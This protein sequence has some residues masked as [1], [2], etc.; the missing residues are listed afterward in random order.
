MGLHRL[1]K[2]SNSGHFVPVRHRRRRPSKDETG[3][4]I[5]ATCRRGDFLWPGWAAER[6]QAGFFLVSPPPSSPTREESNMLPCFCTC[7]GSRGL[8]APECRSSPRWPLGPGL[9]SSLLLNLHSCFVVVPHRRCRPAMDETV[10]PTSRSAVAWASSPTPFN[11]AN[12]V[13]LVSP[14]PASSTRE[15]LNLP[16][17]FCTCGGIR[18]LQ[19]TE[20]R[21]S[22]RGPSPLPFV[23]FNLRFI[24]SC[25]TTFRRGGCR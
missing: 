18:G 15:Q 16:T 10:P 9:F 1:R 11:L 25:G 4:P 22:P 5:L 21:S 20:C 3:C 19:A 17:C 6:I 7:G 8:Q 12:G 24:S 13:F 23:L 14:P 2:N